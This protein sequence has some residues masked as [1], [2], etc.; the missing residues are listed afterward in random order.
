MTRP[1][2]PFVQRMYVQQQREKFLKMVGD[3][4]LRRANSFIEQAQAQAPQPPPIPP[5]QV[6]SN[7][8]LPA[9][10]QV[11]VKNN[12]NTTMSPAVP[13]SYQDMF[14]F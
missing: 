12:K 13:L 7:N 8:R 6:I 11:V 5:V 10:F 9:D 2:P 4:E 14:I 1:A 3:A